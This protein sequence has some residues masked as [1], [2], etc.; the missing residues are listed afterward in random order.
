MQQIYNDWFA[1]IQ[2]RLNT[3]GF[4]AFFVFSRLNTPGFDFFVFSSSITSRDTIY[5]GRQNS[6]DSHVVIDGAHRAVS[7]DNAVRAA[8]RQNN[9]RVLAMMNGVGAKRL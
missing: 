6:D 9:G 1:T 3:P 8:L 2:S 5:S 4:D 7:E